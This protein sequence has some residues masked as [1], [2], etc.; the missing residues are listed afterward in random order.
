MLFLICASK[1]NTYMSYA[2]IDRSAEGGASQC[3]P[4]VARGWAERDGGCLV[5]VAP[6]R[7]VAPSGLS[8]HRGGPDDR[9]AGGGC[10]AGGGGDVQASSE[11]GRRHPGSSGGRRDDDQ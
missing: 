11:P 8:V 3:G 5:V 1:G 10:R 4:W 2:A 9:P 7:N 6:V